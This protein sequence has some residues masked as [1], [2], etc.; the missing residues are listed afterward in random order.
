MAMPQAEIEATMA[1]AL[2]KVQ[3]CCL[4]D[5]ADFQRVLASVVEAALILIAL[6]RDRRS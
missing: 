5:D 6:D 1:A 3:A 2:I 4:D